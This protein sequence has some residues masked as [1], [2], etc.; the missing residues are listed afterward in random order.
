[1]AAAT[2]QTAQQSDNTL[3]FL[4]LAFQNLISAI[5]KRSYFLLKKIKK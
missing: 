3:N 2:Q 5:L 1:M 4:F